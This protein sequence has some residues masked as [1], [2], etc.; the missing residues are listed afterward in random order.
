MFQ[1]EFIG[2]ILIYIGTKLHMSGSKVSLVIAIKRKANADLAQ[3]PYSILHPE[4]KAT[5][6]RMWNIFR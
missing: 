2:T 1:T 5:H 6:Y 3:Q 4:E